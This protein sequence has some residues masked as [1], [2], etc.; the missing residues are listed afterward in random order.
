MDLELEKRRVVRR[1]V[2]RMKVVRR[3]VVRRRVVYRY[4]WKQCKTANRFFVVVTSLLVVLVLQY[5]ST[6]VTTV[7]Q[8]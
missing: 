8:S 1:R 4:T 5:N 6:L 7:L 3:R 2:V